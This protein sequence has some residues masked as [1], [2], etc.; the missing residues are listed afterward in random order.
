MILDEE[1]YNN[2][3]KKD[4]KAQ[5][6]FYKN[7]FSTMM[8]VAYRYKNNKDDAAI[9]VNES[10]LK[11]LDNITSYNFDKPLDAWIRR[12]TI[13]T[14]IDDFRKHKNYFNQTENID[15]ITVENNTTQTES[16]A[17]ALQTEHI[18]LL[19]KNLLPKAT[20]IVFY[21]YAIDGFSHIDIANQLNIS[22]ETSKWHVKYARKIL[23]ENKEK[24]L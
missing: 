7:C 24:F 23:R 2:L 20:Q 15:E 4:K 6:L 21:L 14:A 18:H 19:L 12:I 8:N 11:V 10:F 17:D 13:N 5:L 16:I 9:L 3:I 1:L 22:Q